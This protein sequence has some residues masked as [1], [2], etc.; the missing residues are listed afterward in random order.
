M[1]NLVNHV[2]V[3]AFSSTTVMLVWHLC[4]FNKIKMFLDEE[5]KQRTLCKL[6]L[7]CSFFHRTMGLDNVA[8]KECMNCRYVDSLFKLS[9]SSFFSIFL[10][11]ARLLVHTAGRQCLISVINRAFTFPEQQGRLNLKDGQ[12]GTGEKRRFSFLVFR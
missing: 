9:C 5:E 2:A 8:L 6:W 7:D 10:N 1:Y 3:R 4:T 11:K 12:T